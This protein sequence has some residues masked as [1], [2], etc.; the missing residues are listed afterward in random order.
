MRL[1][2]IVIVILVGAGSNCLVLLILRP[3]TLRS[4][5]LSPQN[6]KHWPVKAFLKINPDF[7]VVIASGESYITHDFNSVQVRDYV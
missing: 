1:S 6:F 7:L 4:I 3:L 5:T 2:L